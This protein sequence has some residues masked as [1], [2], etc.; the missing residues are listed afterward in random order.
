MHVQSKGGHKLGNGLS[1][2]Y[3]T[4]HFTGLL[5]FRTPVCS[6]IQIVLNNLQL[7]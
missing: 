3:Q 2:I 5:Q 1:P 6:G 4:D 7:P